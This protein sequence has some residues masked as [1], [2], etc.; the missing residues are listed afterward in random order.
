MS[1]VLVVD[2]D[3]DVRQIL[4]EFIELEGHRVIEAPNVT[5]L[6]YRVAR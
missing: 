6:K 1:T 5:H 4:R 2:D 3:P